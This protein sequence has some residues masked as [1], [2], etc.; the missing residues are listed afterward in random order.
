MAAMETTTLQVLSC[1]FQNHVAGFGDEQRTG[2]LHKPLLL[3]ADGSSPDTRGSCGSTAGHWHLWDSHCYTWAWVCRLN[4]VMERALVYFCSSKRLWAGWLRVRLLADNSHRSFWKQLSGSIVVKR[5][6]S[7]P[8]YLFL[9]LY[10]TSLAT[11]AATCL[12]SLL[13]VL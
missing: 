8:W 2:L 6:E 13:R 7:W 4:W 10:Y 12:C 1:C 5:Q 9:K 11:W 3:Q